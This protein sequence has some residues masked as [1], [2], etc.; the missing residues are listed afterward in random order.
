[1]G[2]RTRNLDPRSAYD[3]KRFARTSEGRARAPEEDRAA[4]LRRSGCGDAACG[5]CAEEGAEEGEGAASACRTCTGTMKMRACRRMEAGER[6]PRGVHATT[7]DG[8]AVV[9]FCEGLMRQERCNGCVGSSTRAHY[10]HVGRRAHG[11]RRTTRL[12]AGVRDKRERGRGD[13]YED[14]SVGTHTS[15]ASSSSLRSAVSRIDDPL[16]LHAPSLPILFPSL[17]HSIS[18]PTPT[19]HGTV[20]PRR[21]ERVRTRAGQVCCPFSSS[22]R[23]VV[24]RTGHGCLLGVQAPDS[25]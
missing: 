2:G 10:A 18:Q 1:M 23:P 17:P 7:E 9:E 14:W 21:M 12:W 8:S 25:T 15:T 13:A 6:Q 19:D 24:C 4:R 5:V 11:G 3:P 22:S 20:P 16:A